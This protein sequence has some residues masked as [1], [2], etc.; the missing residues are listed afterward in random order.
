[1]AQQLPELRDAVAVAHAFLTPQGQLQH[2]A[3]FEGVADHFRRTVAAAPE[4]LQQ[5]GAG[6]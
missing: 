6:A 2:K 1:M 5:V 3:L 4:V